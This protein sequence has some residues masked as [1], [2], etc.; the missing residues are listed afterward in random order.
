VYDQ[1]RQELSSGSIGEVKGLTVSFGVA[2][3]RNQ[4]PRFFS[5]EL[6]GGVVREL[7]VYPI[8]LA[9]LVFNNEKPEKIC[10]NGHLLDNGEFWLLLCG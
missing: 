8:Q 4:T 10:V 5:K 7:G 2:F 1:L 9:C 6:G 3:D